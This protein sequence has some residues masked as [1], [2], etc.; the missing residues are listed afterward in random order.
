M[1]ICQECR[2]F[3]GISGAEITI[4]DGGEGFS[5]IQRT[6][7]SHVSSINMP[8]LVIVFGVPGWCWILENL[9][10]RVLDTAE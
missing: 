8:S 6:I 1:L 7:V 5:P 9:V 2:L 4:V 3:R 10:I